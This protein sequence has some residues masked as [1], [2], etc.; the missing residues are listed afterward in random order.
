MYMRIQI[1]INYMSKAHIVNK[2]INQ[3]LG[4]IKEGGKTYYS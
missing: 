3:K 1:I 2:C 4:T